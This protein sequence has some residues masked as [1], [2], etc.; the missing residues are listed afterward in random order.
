[1]KRY[2]LFLIAL[3]ITACDTQTIGLNDGIYQGET[4]NELPSGY[5]EWSKSDGSQSYQG[6]WAN[7]KMNGS[8]TLIKGDSCYRGEVKDNLYNGYGELLYKDSLLYAGM[9][10]KGKRTR[11]CTTDSLG[12]KIIGQWNADTLVSGKR[13]DPLGIYT[14]KMNQKGQ[15]EGHGVYQSL[16]GDYYDGHWINDKRSIFGFAVTAANGLKIGEWRENKFLGERVVY[17]SDRIYGIDI[18]KYQHETTTF[19]TKRVRVKVHNKRVLRMV[20]RP[21]VHR[22]A[23]NWDK[24]RITH[25]GTLSKKKV[26]GEADYPISFVYVKSTEGT[27]IRNAYYANDCKQIRKRGMHAG[28]YHFFSLTSSPAA[29]ARYF[30]KNT[31][32]Q[33]GDFP[34]VL[35]VEPSDKQ[36]A[37]IGGGEVL[38]DRIR[39]WMNIVEQQTGVKPILYVSQMFVN[40]YLSKAPDI[41]NNYMV[42]IARY[43]E[44]KP[45]VKLIYW[46][47][48][49]DGTVN[50]IRS[51]V[52]INVFNGYSTQ[53]DEF[54]RTNCF[55]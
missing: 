7:G 49:P 36:I 43:G 1:M 5:G 38:F 26:N 10:F 28:A 8:G 45:D 6:F 52:D 33:T 46:Q 21:V 25:L 18:S 34:P 11:G 44:Y 16:N 47:L 32:F 55:Q 3:L 54:V 17:T 50:G 42:W 29:Q 12:R 53:Y 19:V 9:W 23:I 24:V 22:H 48:C 31:S 15:A 13:I 40:Q 51:Q 30:L 14:G 2:H 37:S 20:K 39:I 4:A 35:D 27:S 41:K